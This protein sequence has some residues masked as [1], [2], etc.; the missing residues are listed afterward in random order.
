MISRTNPS[1]RLMSQTSTQKEILEAKHFNSTGRGPTKKT[2]A[3][4]Q[5]KTNMMNIVNERCLIFWM[6]IVEKWFRVFLLEKRESF[7]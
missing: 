7:F 1:R 4:N 3:D 5:L 6:K 2:I